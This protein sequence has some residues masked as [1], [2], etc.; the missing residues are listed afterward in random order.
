M[1]IALTVIAALALCAWSTVLYAW[2]EERQRRTR[3]ATIVA[4]AALRRRLDAELDD[5]RVLVNAH[6]GIDLVGWLP[7]EGIELDAEPITDEIPVVLPET[8]PIGRAWDESAAEL[9][10]PEPVPEL[11][12]VERVVN[13]FTFRVR[14]EAA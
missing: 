12:T 7:D 9:V 11:R 4:N 13:G 1:R 6:L 8:V 3:R 14:E 5:L 2:V 10:D